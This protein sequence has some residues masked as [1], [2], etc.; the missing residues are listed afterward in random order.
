M[1]LTLRPATDADRP[2]LLTVY[3][4]TRERE[5]ERVPW[6]YEQKASFLL[7]QFNA[8]DTHYREHYPEASFDVI[9]ADGEPVGRLYVSRWPEEIRI[10]DIALLPAA[11]GRGLGSQLLNDLFEESRQSGKPVSIHVEKENPARR[12]YDRLGFR[13]VE[14]RGVYLLMRREVR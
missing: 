6:D 10:V 4:S 13:E 3:A 8:Q 12:L 14:D 11:R 9:E 2:F 7:M 1:S 5:M